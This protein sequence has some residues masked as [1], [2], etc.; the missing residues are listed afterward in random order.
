MNKT[1]V[2]KQINHIKFELNQVSDMVKKT[3]NTIDHIK[4][5]LKCLHVD[6]EV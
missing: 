6:L 1:E 5:E 3:K 2:I 4:D